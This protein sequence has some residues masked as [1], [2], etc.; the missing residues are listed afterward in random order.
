VVFPKPAKLA[1]LRKGTWTSSVSQLVWF[2]P[3]FCHFLAIGSWQFAL[4]VWASS[5]QF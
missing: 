3:C 1:F 4:P 5:S 2:E